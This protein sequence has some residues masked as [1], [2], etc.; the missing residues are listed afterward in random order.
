[1]NIHK[2]TRQYEQWLTNFTPLIPADLALKHQQMA[3]APFPFL[4]ST[5]YR[6]VQVWLEICKES[7]KA[8]VVLAVG[9]LHVENFGT[10]RDTE[11]RMI[12]GVNDFDEADHL[13]Y[14]ND[15]VRLA[16]SAL[17]AIEA[18]HLRLSGS[19]ACGSILAGYQDGLTAGG[20][21]YVLAEDHAWLRKLATGVL[22]DPVH[23]WQKMDAL[24]EVKEP[25]PESAIAALEYMLPRTGVIYRIR[26]RVAGLGSLGRPRYVAIAEWQGGK[27]AREAKTLLPSSTVWAQAEKP[28]A[29][30]FYQAIIERAVRCRDPYVQLQGHWIVRRLAPY[31]SRVELAALPEEREEERLLHAMG[32]ETANIHLGSREAIRAVKQDLRKRSKGWLQ[33]AA[34]AMTAAVRTDWE[35]WKEGEKPARAKS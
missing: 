12:W 3:V 24:P 11:G 8:P 1:M 31:C 9:D 26:H 17:F 33:K 14:T 10:W 16:T 30:I 7:A 13:P 29:E 27:I 23:F 35:R 20:R 2:A 22:R 34:E 28:A 21:P 32:W 15:L 6:W 5:F 4:R 25:V 19:G 18:G